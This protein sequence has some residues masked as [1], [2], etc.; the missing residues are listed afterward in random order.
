MK[1]KRR[2]AS[3]VLN[4]PIKVSNELAQALDMDPEEPTTRQKVIQ[5]LYKVP[6]VKT[7]SNRVLSLPDTLKAVLGPPIHPLSKKDDTVCYSF[8]N[9]MKYLMDHMTKF[10]GEAVTTQEEEQ[11]EEAAAIEEAVATE[12]QK[13]VKKPKKRVQSKSKAG[14]SATTSAVEEE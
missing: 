11:V 8:Y 3:N 14:P 12:V 6:G 7:S 9:I 2:N 1:A 10:E 13:A 5:R 4:A